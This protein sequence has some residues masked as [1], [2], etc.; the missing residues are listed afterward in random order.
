[1]TINEQMNA[2]EK[3]ILEIGGAR[4][5]AQKSKVEGIQ[6]HMNLAHEEVTKAEVAKTK[7]EKDVRKLAGVITT[8]TTTL[9]NVAT[10]LEGLEEEL[11][12]C[13]RYLDDITSKVADAQTA[14]ENSKD[15]LEE[16]KAELDEKTE[17]IRT[18]RAKEVSLCFCAWRNG[19]HRGWTRWSSSNA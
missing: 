2:L 8:N 9:D 16:R 3:K 12:E 15:D 17:Q 7:A 10:D 5:L 1:M 13:N 19:A 4:L 11:K 18:F 6:L 14:V